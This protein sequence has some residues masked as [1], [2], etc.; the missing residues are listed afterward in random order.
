MF[1]TRLDSGWMLA[2]MFREI[3]KYE[4]SVKRFRNVRPGEDFKGYPAQ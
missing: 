4:Q 3:A 2:P 1:D